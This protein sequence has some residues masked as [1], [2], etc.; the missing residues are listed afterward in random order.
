[1]QAYP[2]IFFKIEGKRSMPAREGFKARS[3][4]DLRHTSDWTLSGRAH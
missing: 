2:S 3:A 1:L 4:L